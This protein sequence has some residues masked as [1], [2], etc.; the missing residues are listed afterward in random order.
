[1]AQAERKA[2]N[3]NITSSSRDD[4]REYIDSMLGD[5]EAAE[6]VVNMREV[7]HFIKSLRFR[8]TLSTFMP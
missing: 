1:M 8:N 7:D 4:Y 6:R 2:I 5:M 3:K